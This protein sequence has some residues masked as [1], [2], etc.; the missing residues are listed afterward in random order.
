M[1][2]REKVVTAAETIWNQLLVFGDVPGGG[3]TGL[4]G[5]ETGSS[6]PV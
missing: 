6:L 1:S 3:S 2:R 4:R 5:I